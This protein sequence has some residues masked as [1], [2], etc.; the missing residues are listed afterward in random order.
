CLLAILLDPE[1][2]VGRVAIALLAPE[3]RATIARE[4]QFGA[5]WNRSFSGKAPDGR[6]AS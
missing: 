1:Q 2:S 3:P 6:R 4:R 5:V